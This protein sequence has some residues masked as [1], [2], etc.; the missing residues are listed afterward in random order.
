MVRSLTEIISTSGLL[1]VKVHLSPKKRRN[2]LRNL[3]RNLCG[4]RSHL[5]V[6]PSVGSYPVNIS[7]HEWVIVV[8]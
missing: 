2:E 6:T 8:T 5:K 3:R 7:K 4:P 1:V